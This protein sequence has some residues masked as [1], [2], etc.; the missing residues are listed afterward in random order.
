MSFHSRIAIFDSTNVDNVGKFL[1]EILSI[2]RNQYETDDIR[3]SLI[4]TEKV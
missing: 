1:L 2:T 4:V 3:S